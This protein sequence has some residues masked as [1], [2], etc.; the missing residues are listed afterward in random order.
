MRIEYKID[1][2]NSIFITPTLS[3]Q[4]NNAVSSIFGNNDYQIKDVTS[5][6]SI[7]RSLNQNDRSTSGYNISNSI[8]YRHAF[9]K[10]GRTISLN[11]TT[12]LNE[13]EGDNYLTAYNQ[14]FKKGPNVNDTVQQYSDQFSNGYQLSANLVY[15][16]PLGKK[17][18]LQFNY[19]P[20]Y[21]KSK[22]DQK[23]F[24]FDQTNEKYSQLDSSLSNK[25]D[26]DYI[27][28]NGGVTYRLGDRDKMLSVGLAYQTS[29]LNSDQFYPYTTKVR[30]TFH[31]F[32]P[33]LMLRYKLSAKSNLNIFY[34][35]ATNPPSINQLVDVI[36]NT[37]PLFLSTGNP[38]LDQQYSQTFAV[39]YSFTNSAKGQ[40]L[41]A[42]VFVQQAADYISNA[43]YTAT[44]DSILTNSVTLY[45]GSQ[46]SKPVNLDGYWSVR[47]FVTYGMPL[48]FIKSNL[49]WNAGFSYVRTPG[50]I[51]GVTT[52][53][54]SYNYNLGAVIG[55]NVSQYVDFN[56]SYSAN[57]N[58]ARNSIQPQLNSN[59]FSQTAGIQFN[60][61]SKNG[62]FLQNDL[63]N[64][65]YKGLTD[66]FNQNYWLWN[67]GAG[68]KFLKDQKAELKVTAFDLLKQNRSINRT[69]DENSIQD[70]QNQVLQQYFMLTFT[71]KLRNFGKASARAQRNEGT[72]R[73]ENRMMEGR[74]PQP[75]NF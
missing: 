3:Y 31:N 9:K 72:D 12:G 45:Q 56:L 38:E 46:L 50:V 70:V 75:R 5:L 24:A 15:T 37:N 4:K 74:P 67:M 18:S 29:D 66:G 33:N 54:D 43:T 1:S 19:N 25:F 13:R 20:S 68:K 21:S 30:K 63:N 17:G 52:M 27:T 51:N 69:V 61:L 39:R 64:Q 26:N 7:S 2:N 71:Y 44:K 11:V 73:P 34:R 60:I 28:Q 14:Y 23:T 10:R 55:S 62:W 47:S 41:F 59:Y 48:K 35:T 6:D 40:S 16:E 32:L 58:V 8:L 49:N 53:S 57:F 22:S 65:S 36:N 42:N